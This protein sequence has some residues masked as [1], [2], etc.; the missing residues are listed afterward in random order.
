MLQVAGSNPATQ[1]G[2]SVRWIGGSRSTERYRLPMVPCVR[3]LDPNGKQC[4]C[5]VLLTVWVFYLGHL[6][7]QEECRS[8]EP[9]AKVRFL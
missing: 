2:D 9:E 7:Q 5:A 3:T 6:T 1:I 8:E 4:V